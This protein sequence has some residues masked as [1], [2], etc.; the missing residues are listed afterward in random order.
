MLFRVTRN[1]YMLQMK[2]WHN[3]FTSLK[4]NVS[5]SCIELPWQRNEHMHN[6]VFFVE[7]ENGCIIISKQDWICCLPCQ[8]SLVTIKQREDCFT[9]KF[10][11]VWFHIFREH[12]KCTY[13]YIKSF[14]YT[15]WWAP[16]ARL[17]SLSGVCSVLKSPY[18]IKTNRSHH[19]TVLY[20]NLA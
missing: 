9:K 17:K 14:C 13:D 18:L 6:Y 2:S 11:L 19:T 15:N 1:K 8:Q 3:L 16:W 10:S 5:C 12:N 4:R 20:Q 7:M